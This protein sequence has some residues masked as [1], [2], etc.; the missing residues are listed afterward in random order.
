MDNLKQLEEKLYL[1][2]NHECEYESTKRTILGGNTI[3][4]SQCKICFQGK[5]EKI[6]GRNLDHLPDFDDTSPRIHDIKE[7]IRVTKLESDRSEFFLWY[8]EY[9]LT[10]EWRAKREK[11]MAR[12]KGVCEG[13]SVR[14]A[15]QV[16]HLSYAH[17][18]NEF[19]WELVGICNECHNQVHEKE[20]TRIINLT[21]TTSK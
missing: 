18:G 21:T 15:S 6:N 11:V 7:R 4:W 3:A 5:A 1:Y 19:L 2:E 9:L 14:P 20:E 16:H 17:V 13:C 8:S 12:C 10:P